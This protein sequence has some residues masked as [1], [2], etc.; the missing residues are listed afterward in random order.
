AAQRL[1]AVPECLFRAFALRQVEHESD[2]LIPAFLEGCRADQHGNTAAVFPEV[3]L[4]KRLQTPGHLQLGHASFIAVTPF[5]WRQLRPTYATRDE[6]LTVVADHAEKCV[7]RLDD[8]AFEIPD[9]DADDV[10]SNQARV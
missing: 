5:G 6:I 1:F 2:T 4:L 3:L 8:P 7:V 10:G 9:E